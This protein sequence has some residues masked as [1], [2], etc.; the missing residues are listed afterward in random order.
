MPSPTTTAALLAAVQPLA[1]YVARAPAANAHADR[2]AAL[3]DAVA[4]YA[5]EVE[6]ENATPPGPDWQHILDRVMAYLEPEKPPTPL[7]VRTRAH[8]DSLQTR[9]ALPLAQRM[10]QARISSHHLGIPDSF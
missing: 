4:D 10:A 8:L 9:A 5:E 7:M 2:C 1:A 6:A 3:V